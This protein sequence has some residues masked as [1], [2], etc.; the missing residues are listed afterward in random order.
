[1]TPQ[2]PQTTPELLVE[3][4]AVASPCTPLQLLLLVAS[5]AV[6]VV[7][8]VVSWA[9]VGPFVCVGAGSRC[10][11]PSRSGSVQDPGG[12]DHP[13]GFSFFYAEI[14]GLLS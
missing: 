8:A 2:T 10:M 9:V 14:G 3:C 12:N 6:A 5:D 1:M 11:G 7:V 13:F 4:H